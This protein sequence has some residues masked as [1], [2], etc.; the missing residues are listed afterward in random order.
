MQKKAD[1]ITRSG[2]PLVVG[3][4]ATLS[5]VGFAEMAIPSLEVSPSHGMTR[6][7]LGRGIAVAAQTPSA[8]IIVYASELPRGALSEFAF[9]V[10]SASPGGK[11]AVTPN[12]GGNLDPPPED[13]PHV[14]FKVRVQAG[15]PYRCWIHMKVGTPKGESQANK[16]WVQ[17]SDAVD[18]AN[19]P[20]LKPGTGSYL[21]AQ[22]PTRSGWTW[23]GCDMT[24][25]PS[26]ETLIT[27]KV[28]GDITVR[29]QAGME[30]VGF[31]Q[32]LL[33]PA[34]FLKVPP[35]EAV[36]RKS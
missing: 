25:A 33:S 36:V 5:F 16:F 15:V 32:F 27:F 29:M 18:K 21:T 10:D 1:R 34:K 26:P 4:F 28:T 6:R 35:A 3:A 23:V 2:L 30:G 9:R 24:E 7:A 14:T 22:G 8:E 17:F 20:V 12:T 13:D 11:F 31:D 19:K